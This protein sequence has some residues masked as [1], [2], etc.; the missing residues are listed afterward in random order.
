MV[1][2]VET[3]QTAAATDEQS[4]A[5]EGLPLPSS[6]KISVLASRPAPGA[7]DRVNWSVPLPVFVRTCGAYKVPPE[8]PVLVLMTVVVTPVTLSSANAPT[9]CTMVTTGLEVIRLGL[10]VASVKLA[11]AVLPILVSAAGA[12]AIA[13]PDK[14]KSVA[15]N[16]PHD[17]RFPFGG[18][19]TRWE[20]VGFFTK[21]FLDFG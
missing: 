13:P 1:N 12:A 6:A 7:T 19:P 20:D 2:G 14:K 17:A 16:A 10:P 4:A 5:P 18:E 15:N 21:W 9:C 3:V 11:V 8:T